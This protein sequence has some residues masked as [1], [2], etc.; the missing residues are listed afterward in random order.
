MK[1]SLMKKIIAAFIGII[2]LCCVSLAAVSYN[3]IKNAVED[4]MQQDG[5]TLVNSL[6]QQVE[7]NH[8]DSLDELQGIFQGIKE[9]SLGILVY[10]SFSDVNG[11]VLVSDSFIT[12]EAESVDAVSAAT[13]KGDGESVVNDS[14]TS[15]S[16]IDTTSGEKVYNV[17]TRIEVGQEKGAFNLGISLENMNQEIAL[18]LME[19]IIIS[20]VV[21]AIAMISAIALGKYITRPIRLMSG[22]IEELSIICHIYKIYIQ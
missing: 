19:I 3:M 20:L 9:N 16:V 7:R 22:R 6:K 13:S 15:G 18:A 10:V 14:K 1:N 12:T 17:S 4:Q 21:M 2:I 11:N 8:V 5:T